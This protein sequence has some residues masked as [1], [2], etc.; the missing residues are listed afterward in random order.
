MRKARTTVKRAKGQAVPAETLLSA[1]ATATVNAEHLK[2]LL[3]RLD[4]QKAVLDQH[5]VVSECDVDGNFTYVND[6]LCRISGYSREEL[7]GKPHSVVNSGSHPPEL[8][9]SMYEA[10]IKG[11]VWQSEVCNRRKDGSE[12]WLI[13]TIA[14][15]RNDAGEIV[16]YVDVGADITETKRLQGEILRRGRLEQL[17]QLTA[18][19]AHEIRNPL[20][21]VKT[22][23]Y[24]LERKVAD[25]NANLEVAGAAKLDV[26]SQMQR[27]HNGVLR[28]DR[29]ISELL[30]F[31]RTKSVSK[32]PVELD[33]WL[34]T[35]VDEERRNIP[36]LVE[37]CVEPGLGGMKVP[38]DREQLRRALINLMCNSSEAM[39]G[40]NGDAG[41]IVTEKP[42]I[43]ISTRPAGEAIDIVVSDNGP[44]MTAEHL[45][46]IREPLFT[47]K[48]F[49][50]GLGVPAV[51]KIVE[52]HG[53]TLTIE[54]VPGQGTAVTARIPI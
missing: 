34:S 27:I 14:A 3:A 17:G 13:Q 53:G 37:V 26:A 15:V 48:S 50:I 28:C 4:L 51:E 6:A 1:L 9:K 21:A 18:T 10:V 49:G 46:K 24:V 2:G 22:A 32:K 20:G 38:I 5:A 33:A 44:G 43:C 35:V 42:R 19:V 11:G 54:S 30:D 29:I 52:S 16:A 45:A 41:S 12:F 39:V 8:W 25:F 47:T 36:A 31:A 7:I 23:A 40:R